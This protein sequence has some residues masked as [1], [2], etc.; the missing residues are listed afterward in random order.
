[1]VT[2]D[3]TKIEKQLQEFHRAAIQ[4]MRNMVIFF[5]YKVA[6]EAVENTPIGTLNSLYYKP[7]RLA[8]MEPEVGSAKGGWTASFNIPANITDPGSGRADDELAMNVKDRI[9]SSLRPYKLGDTVFLTNA[10]PYVAN[11]GW[12]EPYY[13]SLEGGYS[14][15]APQGIMKPTFAMVQSVFSKGSSLVQ[16]YNTRPI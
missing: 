2:C 3:T 4:R 5:S 8:V 12:T 7:S 6:V 15:Q 14:Q 10:V 9:Y 13:G 11:S 16:Y 1:M